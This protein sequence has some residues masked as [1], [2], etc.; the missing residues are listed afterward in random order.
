MD[1]LVCL[2][3]H[4]VTHDQ[5]K[6]HPGIWI[7]EIFTFFKISES[8][9]LWRFNVTYQ[10]SCFISLYS[11]CSTEYAN[12][13]LLSSI[14]VPDAH[15]HTYTQSLQL[16]SI[17]VVARCF[18]GSPLIWP[19]L[20]C[21]LSR[22]A[23]HAEPVFNMAAQPWSQ[24]NNKLYLQLSAGLNHWDYG[25]TE[26]RIPINI[27]VGGGKKKVNRLQKDKYLWAS[28]RISLC[29]LNFITCKYRVEVEENEP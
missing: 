2:M 24:S 16:N 5:I 1:L 28:G 15:T 4:E 9:W 18:L 21:L 8:F 13:T 19:G 27:S 14:C 6:K 11:L 10:R 26:S 7:S 23:W 25:G 29:N 22:P 3:W 17:T 20:L 12:R